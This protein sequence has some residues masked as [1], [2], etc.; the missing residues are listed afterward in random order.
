[1]ILNLHVEIQRGG[2]FAVALDGNQ[3]KAF[4]GVGNDLLTAVEDWVYRNDDTI[5][6]IEDELMETQ[7]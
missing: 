1:M 3:E 7:S 6:Q 4:T 2:N 5:N